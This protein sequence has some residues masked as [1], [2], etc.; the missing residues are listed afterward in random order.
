VSTKYLASLPPGGLPPAAGDVEHPP[1]DDSRADRAHDL[2]EHAAVDVE[3]GEPPAFAVVAPRPAHHPVVQDFAALAQ[4]APGRVV[5]PGDEAVQRHGD[6]GHQLAHDS[7][8][9]LVS[10]GSPQDGPRR[11]PRL[12]VR[13]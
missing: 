5:R 7:S 3:R 2:L 9:C 11:R 10:P 13:S 4:A 12:I 8:C 1:A 6:V